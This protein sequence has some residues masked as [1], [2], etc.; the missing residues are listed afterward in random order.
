MIANDERMTLDTIV[1]DDMIQE[2][3]EMV[4]YSGLFGDR[5]DINKLVEEEN[6][7]TEE[8]EK[9]KK[10]RKPRKVDPNRKLR[11]KTRAAA[12]GSSED[13]WVRHGAD[14]FNFALNDEWL[15]ECQPQGGNY[16]KTK[17]F[18]KLIFY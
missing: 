8:K 11:G 1:C 10:E 9:A 12:V 6:K 15:P 7:K 17:N 13:F 2:V 5:I 14:A 4:A 18:Q 3:A 16:E